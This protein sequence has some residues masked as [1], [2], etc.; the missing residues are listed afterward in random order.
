MPLTPE[1]EKQEEKRGLQ[2]V[3]VH[4]VLPNYSVS[5]VSRFTNHVFFCAAGP[6]EFRPN[7]AGGDYSSWGHVELNL[8]NQSYI[9][10]LILG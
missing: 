5:A 7:R 9:V 10:D 8:Y 2:C 3:L 6:A 4:F 1:G